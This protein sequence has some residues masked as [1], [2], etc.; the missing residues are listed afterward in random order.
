[1]RI[2]ILVLLL[3]AVEFD[4]SSQTIKRKLTMED[5]IKLAQEKSISSMVSKNI[6]ASAYWQYR[7][8]KAERLPS[9]NINAGVGNFNRSLVA[10]QDAATGS[11]A[12]RENYILENN[13]SLSLNQN[14]TA[15]G[16]TL[17]LY[18]SLNRLDQFRP[19]RYVTY[20][21]QPLTLSYIQPLW[22]FN[23]FKW[24][25]KIEPK[26]FEY[27]KREYLEN[28]EMTTITAVNY[29]WN[30]TLDQLNYEMA[31]RNY[32]QS[33]TLY[34]IATERFR[35]GSINKDVLLQLQLNMLNDSLNINSSYITLTST[36]NRLCSYIGYTEDADIELQIDYKLPDILLDYNKVLEQAKQNSSFVLSQ[37]IA[38]LEA[39]K[40]VAQAKGNRGFTA[41]FNARFGM[42][43]SDEKLRRAYGNLRDQEVVG[44]TISLPVFD[45]G[46]G[47]GR[48][49][50]AESQAQTTRNKQEQ[51]MIDYEQEIMLMVMQFNNQRN[52]CEISSRANEIANE[53]YELSV[54]NFTR[55]TISVTD[56]NVAQSSK[57]AALRTYINNMSNYW[58][59]YFS[60][61]K[62]TLYDYIN[63]TNINAEFDKLVK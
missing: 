61:R 24:N 1:M 58:N 41:S 17:S 12:Y 56:M 20:Y 26:N 5:V 60:I 32:E 54:K 10:L 53:S 19:E 28:L 18:S 44:L 30:F 8:Y 3:S 43:K 23:S 22:L 25:K 57:D 49:K 63:N 21:T 35:L 47:K 13:M 36:R 50:M 62:K 51:A 31:K 39:E 42:S 2:F 15:T 40:T 46:M 34:R 52:Q 9:V 38:I 59:Y 29:F 4:L 14:I 55:G 27:A 37:E 6:F 33:K 11:F 7:S 48:V 16:G 45:W